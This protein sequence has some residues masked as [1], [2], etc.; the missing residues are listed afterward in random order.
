MHLKIKHFVNQ[1]VQLI[2]FSTIIGLL[3]LGFQCGKEDFFRNPVYEF[4]EKITLTPYKKTYNIGDTITLQFHTNNKQLFDKLTNSYIP[5]DTS[6]LSINLLY[7]KRYTVDTQPEFY[8]DVYVENPINFLFNTANERDNHLSFT[9]DCAASNYQ[10]KASFIPKKA[11]IFSIDPSIINVY[12]PNKTY[13]PFTTTRFYFNLSDCNKD[14]WLSIPAASRSLEDSYTI[15][16]I[17]NKS[18]F[19]FKVE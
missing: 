17:E 3:S 18:I 1:P 16:K 6:F 10:F 12:C 8:S 9:T 14:V 2:F 4:T 7:R 5:T 13:K 15:P 11:G 19:V